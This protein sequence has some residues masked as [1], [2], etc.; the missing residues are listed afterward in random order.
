MK[1]KI[2]RNLWEK[3]Y[4][5]SD[6]KLLKLPKALDLL[7]VHSPMD[8]RRH[9]SNPRHKLGKRDLLAFVG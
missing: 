1:T 8:A 5:T 3:C 4:D 6:I 9:A 2:N 7:M